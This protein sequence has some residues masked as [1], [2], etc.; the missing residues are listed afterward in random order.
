LVL[1]GLLVLGFL[2]WN[3]LSRESGRVARIQREARSFD[4]DSL[5]PNSTILMVC[6]DQD[7]DFL[8]AWDYADQVPKENLELRKRVE[9]KLGDGSL[10]VGP[11]RAGLRRIAAKAPILFQLQGTTLQTRPLMRPIPLTKGE[12]DTIRAM[13]AGPTETGRLP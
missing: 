12:M 13:G 10:K 5:P 8:C 2:A 9:E 11:F 7:G 4:P 3:I 1:I 6:L